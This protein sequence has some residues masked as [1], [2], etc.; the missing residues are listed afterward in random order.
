MKQEEHRV[1]NQIHQTF[2]R[3]L[4]NNIQKDKKVELRICREKIEWHLY[5]KLNI[6]QY[7]KRVINRIS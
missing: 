6:S 2:Y 7:N 4:L 3:I 1:T 5:I